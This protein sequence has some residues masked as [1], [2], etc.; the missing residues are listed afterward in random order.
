MTAG[1]KPSTQLPVASATRPLSVTCCAHSF[2]AGSSDA[3]R[4]TGEGIERAAAGLNVGR[5]G[6]RR[7]EYV[8]QAGRRGCRGSGGGGM[9]DL[10]ANIVG[11]HMLLLH[12][13]DGLWGYAALGRVLLSVFYHPQFGGEKCI[14]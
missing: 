8:A 9:A 2:R 3:E 11:I 4:S 5:V 1:A 14:E 13:V 7:G 6:N 10:A 12:L